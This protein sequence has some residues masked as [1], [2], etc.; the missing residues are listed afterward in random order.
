MF[1]EHENVIDVLKYSMKRMPKSAD[2]D[3]IINFFP[4]KYIDYTKFRCAKPECVNKEVCLKLH[5]KDFD[6]GR[7][8][9]YVQYSLGRCVDEFTKR[10]VNVM[11]FDQEDIIDFLRNRCGKTIYVCGTLNY[12]EEYNIYSITNPNITTE[13]ENTALTIFPAYVG[14]PSTDYFNYKDYRK[15]L[16]E[17]LDV[18][19]F[20]EWI[21]EYIRKECNLMTLEEAY[22]E[23]HFP[24]T[25]RRLKRALSTVDFN[26]M[27]KYSINLAKQ[28]DRNCTTTAF[29]PKNLKIVSE[30]TK[31]L[32]YELTNDQKQTINS[33]LSNMKTGNCETALVQGDVGSGKTIVAVM[34]MATMAKSSYQSVLVAPT[35]VLA[36]QHYKNIKE[37]CEPFG[38]KTVFLT[39]S[40]KAA[41]KRKITKEINEGKYDII[42]GTHSVLNDDIEYNNL[43]LIVTDEEHKFGVAQREKLRNKSTENVHSISMTATPIPRTL[44]TTLYGDWIN[45][46]TIKEKPKG[47]SPVKT[48]IDNDYENS[49]EFLNEEIKKGHQ[50]YVVAPKIEK[51]TKRKSSVLSV[52]QLTEKLE[53]FFD[54]VN[55]SVKIQSLTGKTSAESKSNILNDFSDNKIQILVSTTVI[56]VGVNIPNATVI[57]ISNAE[58]FGLA[59]LHQLRGR[60]GRSNL[61]SYCLLISDKGNNERLNAL[62][63]TNDGFEIAKQDFYQRGSGDLVGVTQSG[64]TEE[65]AIMLN[66]PKMFE[67]A[68]RYA[69]NLKN[70]SV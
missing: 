22:K 34:L 42:V 17:I 1:I 38:I 13:Y 53:D 47:R 57:A 41:E 23:I 14:V 11:W 8:S 62:V 49:F 64:F 43:A 40:I 33:I 28:K 27:L 36:E 48:I 67:F 20:D 70:L 25:F 9:T 12:S 15:N 51:D 30:I 60:V 32:P 16:R 66:R 61:Q 26:K 18:Y 46:Y 4:K 39:S 29:I 35:T 7:A 58:M 50:C 63:S 31:K 69:K 24:T 56:E 21:P 2:D 55:P 19:Y 10:R 68:Q 59:S 65:I 5:L 3:D 44:A 45:V 37:L 6:I 54:E 52:K